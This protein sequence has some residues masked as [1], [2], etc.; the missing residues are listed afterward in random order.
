MATNAVYQKFG[1]AVVFKNTGGDVAFTLKNIANGAG[2]VSAQWDRGTGALPMLFKLEVALKYAA[3]LAIGALSTIYAYST[4]A[5]AEV[6]NST[7]DAAIATQTLITSNW[8]PACVNVGNAVA[9]GP[10]YSEATVLLTGRYVSLAFWNASG[11]A[12]D[13]NDGT[14]YCRLTPLFDDVQAAA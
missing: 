13:N 7:S 5:T 6:D 8:K 4:T 2:R 9:V 3:N 12:T 14:S 10:F 11:Q 1:T